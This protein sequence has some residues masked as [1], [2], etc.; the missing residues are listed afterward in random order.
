MSFFAACAQRVC[1][2]GKQNRTGDGMTSHGKKAGFF[3]TLRDGK[4]LHERIC[5]NA[6]LRPWRTLLQITLT[7]I[8]LYVLALVTKNYYPT[9]SVEVEK[10]VN[11]WR[12]K[13]HKL[14]QDQHAFE[15]VTAW[16]PLWKEASE[17]FETDAERHRRLA[18]A[19]PAVNP[20]VQTALHGPA[21]SAA[22]QNFGGNAQIVYKTKG[23]NSNVF[24]R[25]NLYAMCRLEQLWYTWNDFDD[26]ASGKDR[27]LQSHTRL[28]NLL[29]QSFVSPGKT[30]S[31]NDPN[32]FPASDCDLILAKSQAEVDVAVK[33]RIFD[34]YEV[35][36]Q[37]QFGFFLDKNFSAMTTTPK[38]TSLTRS[39]FQELSGD[40][41]KA[42]DALKSLQAFLNVESSFFQ[43]LFVVDDKE[44]KFVPMPQFA[45]AANNLEV[46]IFDPA[47]ANA[48]GRMLNLGRD[49]GVGLPITFLIVWAIIFSFTNHS[50][51]CASF[52][53][54]FVFLSMLSGYTG[55]YLLAR[56]AYM[57][58]FM[59]LTLFLM[60]AVGA[61]DFFVI[62]EAVRLER[63]QARQDAKE[64]L[65]QI[66]VLTAMLEN[67]ELP[68]TAIKLPQE[69]VLRQRDKMKLTRQMLS[70]EVQVKDSS[71]AAGVSD[72][73]S[74]PVSIDSTRTAESR[75]IEIYLALYRGSQR[76]AASMME[77]SLTT[78]LAFFSMASSNVPPIASFGM[79]A[80]FMI[81]GSYVLAVLC[82]PSVIGAYLLQLE[83][84]PTVWQWC[85]A[86]LLRFFNARKQSNEVVQQDGETQKNQGVTATSNNGAAALMMLQ[87]GSP[88]VIDTSEQH[89]KSTDGNKNCDFGLKNLL[90]E[91]TPEKLQASDAKLAT[92]NKANANQLHNGL[93]Q[94]AFVAANANDSTPTAAIE[95]AVAGFP[96]EKKPGNYANTG[97]T[98]M[99][100][101]VA[102]YTNEEGKQEDGEQQQQRTTRLLDKAMDKTF[103]FLTAKRITVKD[104]YTLFPVAL[105]TVLL[106]TSLSI[107]LFAEATTLPS[108]S[109]PFEF[110]P[111]THIMTGFHSDN[112]QLFLSSGSKSEYRKLHIV[113][114]LNADQ[115]LKN[116]DELSKFFPWTWNADPNLVPIDATDKDSVSF[117]LRLG[118]KLQNLNCN[119]KSFCKDRVVGNK[120]FVP[121]S[122]ECGLRDTIFPQL[123]TSATT[124]ATKLTELYYDGVGGGSTA[125]ISSTLDASGGFDYT[126]LS[127]P[128]WSAATAGA[129]AGTLS[130]G[131][132]A[133]ESYY[134]SHASYD[135]SARA[136]HSS[137]VRR[138]SGGTS[139]AADDPFAVDWIETTDAAHPGTGTFAG[140]VFKWKGMSSAAG[141]ASLQYQLYSLTIS[142]PL[143]A[144]KDG[145]SFTDLESLKETVR[146]LLDQ[147]NARAPAKL[148]KAIQIAEYGTYTLNY[149]LKQTLV[150]GL[151]L[152]IPL[153]FAI[154]L[155]ASRNLVTAFLA[156]FNVICIVSQV[157][158]SFRLMDWELGLL[159]TVAGILVI[160][161]AMDYTLHFSHVYTEA[162]R[163]DSDA[164]HVEQA[165]DGEN[166]HRT[167][168]DPESKLHSEDHDGPTHSY[169]SRESRVQF[170]F[171][172]MG[173]T[174]FAGFSTSIAA[175]LFLMLFCV[176][177]FFQQM[178]VAIFL[179][180]LYSLVMSLFYLPAVLLLCGPS[181]K[182]GDLVLLYREFKAR[183]IGEARGSTGQ[184]DESGIRNG[185]AA[186]EP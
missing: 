27:F 61:D 15:A 82:F 37:A 30:L 136:R 89:H 85:K 117:I 111:D 43:P 123:R 133:K 46:R 109:A 120:M 8:V 112:Y 12:P 160:G 81:L 84:K 91:Q 55:Y 153:C 49:L 141:G 166:K 90:Q 20:E 176:T 186:V 161:L 127:N 96:P 98:S 130:A 119:G 94:T 48:A 38:F 71:S 59:S 184:K 10:N 5:L 175:G 83:H 179:T 31:Q 183:T 32:A 35:D 79:F 28:S 17:E 14:M 132:L 95:L 78:A 140:R 86:K 39:G 58:P 108:P 25:G 36:N 157:M 34:R 3:Q 6:V 149:E 93:F 168:V 154:L 22:S 147:E 51:F 137:P 155:L 18:A 77:T 33:E 106:F 4:K 73:L 72:G 134:R 170:A 110:L 70:G 124:P 164:P 7:C 135:Y 19:F 173:P 156:I 131:V 151:I 68:V 62:W 113:W 177:P 163:I 158:G 60:L 44:H 26:G 63:A 9:G 97:T 143:T 52:V 41:A 103:E 67:Y 64:I 74:S 88:V 13:S 128:T 100:T 92:G 126:T 182:F 174:I 118:E 152:L 121:R 142:I 11:I 47:L 105:L 150:S 56:L 53:L 102:N 16:T 2:K 180:I 138:V 181:G 24:T 80:A 178:G 144:L 139:A 75:Q 104:N 167:G 1:G 29:V 69:L 169:E 146:E 148:G 99:F 40:F 172:H 159:E 101:T 45:Q 57:E 162:G 87:E 42:E 115:P 116:H 145:T 125:S 129:A 54:V 171:Q 23:G 122:L 66:E 185:A 76:A 114:G 21:P 107:W 165:A 50:K 65:P